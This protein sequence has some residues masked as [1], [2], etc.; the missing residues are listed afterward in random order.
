[1]IDTLKFLSLSL[2]LCSSASALQSPEQDPGLTPEPSSQEAPE[3]ELQPALML[4]LRSG[5]I[6]WGHILDHDPDGFRFTLLSH[7]GVASV[8]WTAL[9][10]SQQQELREELGYVDVATD[11]LM[12]DV[13]RLI[14]V[15]GHEVVGVILS[16][17]G[18]DFVVQV[19]GNLQLVPKRRVQSISKGGQA[20]AL[21]IY[22]REE[23]YARH[24]AEL[25]ETD[26]QGQINMAR[27]CEQFLDF[28]HALEHFQAAVALDENLEHPELAN[29]VA[30][31]QVKAAQQ[32]Q[33]DYL[34]SVD[35]LRKKGQ[36]ETELERLAGFA[37][38]F[39]AS[40]LVLEVKAKENQIMLARDE[41]V[42]DFVRRRWGYWLSR[43]TR[44]AAGSLDYVGAVAF[45]EEGL[46]EAIREA[47]LADVQEQYNSEASE[48]QIVAHWVSRHMLRY[49]NATYGEGT[50]ML[51]EDKALAG[52][53]DTSAQRDAMT[54]KDKERA[55]L[56]DKIQRFLKNQRNA[57]RAQAQAAQEDE[58]QVFWDAFT[59]SKRA[60]WIKAFYVEFAG[61][62]ELRDHPYLKA[63][64]TCGGR[65]ALEM[66]YSGGGGSK[67]AS[68]VQIVPCHACRGVAVTRRVYYR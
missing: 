33:I 59:L 56:E 58:F 48:D 14:L 28:Q 62:Y 39:P 68:S 36:Y 45:A 50:W 61:D 42:T 67:Q 65:G 53:E 37:L 3:L 10:P 60:N 30:L 47:V 16:R 32:A 43:L 49:N 27:T 35:V 1:M 41:E 38:V 18:T 5:Q 29:S 31:A 20:P 24:S 15:D 19:D 26:L 9:D 13:E 2:F 22:S 66:I 44:Q 7:G 25:V 34:R 57:R 23:L 54:D 51:G 40:P 8:V 21:D 63:C 11:E 52:T 46:G 12:V 17:E 64:S 6:R 55:A 4:K